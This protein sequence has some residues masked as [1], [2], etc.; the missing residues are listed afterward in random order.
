MDEKSNSTQ[1]EKP[2]LPASPARKNNAQEE[3]RPQNYNK[4]GN[5]LGLTSTF[6]V[7]LIMFTLTL[8]DFIGFQNSMKENFAYNSNPMHYMSTLQLYNQTST[9]WS[10]PFATEI[11]SSSSSSS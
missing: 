4:V 10:T 1:E 6:F 7:V 5:G 11:R 8:G 2:S 3:R 9:L